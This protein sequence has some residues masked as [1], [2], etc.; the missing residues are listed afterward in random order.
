MAIGENAVIAL[1]IIGVGV[2][3]IAAFYICKPLYE[4]ERI[5]QINR[6]DAARRVRRARRDAQVAADANAEAA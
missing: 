4:S 5:D 6:M 3:A 2:V 1:I